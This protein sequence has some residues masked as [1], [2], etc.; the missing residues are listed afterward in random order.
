MEENNTQQQ[1][2]T[3]SQPAE[4][5]APSA[6]AYVPAPAANPNP[7]GVA[8][9]KPAG[10]KKLLLIIAAV[11]VLLAG[12]VAAFL[13]LKNDKSSDTNKTSNN[14]DSAKTSSSPTPTPTAVADKCLT[15]EAQL[16]WNDNFD[17]YT[18][19][20]GP[21]AYLQT[22][23]IFF[24]AN[25]AVQEY[26]T[27]DAQDFDKMSAFIIKN[28]AIGYK[29][30]LRGKINQPNGNATAADKALAVSRFEL[31][32]SELVKRGVDANNIV[33]LDP[34][35]DTKGVNSEAARHVEMWYEPT[36]VYVNNKEVAVTNDYEW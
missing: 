7:M 6:P 18:S 16:E 22:R 8:P 23:D 36:C 14:S 17:V 20:T 35:L 12:G 13:L 27:V 29:V 32:K 25:S 33:Q 21:S 5:P 34:L 4:V 24:K 28:K 19:A 30:K 1:S 10:N 3:N 9:V 2:E 11:V 31:V 15:K 26:A